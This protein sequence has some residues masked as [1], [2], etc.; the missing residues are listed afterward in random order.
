MTS[1]P[2]SDRQARALELIRHI[3]AFLELGDAGSGSIKRDTC[4][5]IGVSTEAGRA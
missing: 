3:V 5:V 1:F 2:V 4:V